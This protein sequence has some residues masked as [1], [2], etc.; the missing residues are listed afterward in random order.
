M[1][2]IAVL[3]SGGGTNLQALIDGAPY[4]NGELAFVLSSH[5][6]V[7]ALQRAEDA[8]LE[9]LVINP[10]DYPDRAVY[11]DAVI[12]ALSERNINLV[13]FG[14]FLYILSPSFAETYANRAINVHPAL[15]PSFCGKGYYGLRVH[16]AALDHGAKVTGAT[17]HYVTAGADEGPII[18][19]KAIDILP[20]DTPES[21]QRRVMEQCEWPL[22]VEAV[23]NICLSLR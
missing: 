20:D 4:E 1:I 3:V 9:T 13:V 18:A 6:G 8:G 14:G 12:K 7:Y 5:E 17:V 2:K 23:R 11:T 15:I 16:Q 22:L 21:L 10:K 19:Q